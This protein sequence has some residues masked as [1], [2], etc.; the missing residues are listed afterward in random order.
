MSAAEA[1]GAAPP[2]NAATAPECPEKDSWAGSAADPWAGAAQ[3]PQTQ[4]TPQ[5]QQPEQDPWSLD[6]FNKGKGKGSGGPLQCY[7]F[8]GD[9]HPQF[10]CAS[11]KGAGEAGAG[12]VCDNC[13]GTGHQAAACTSKGGGKHTPKGQGKG[14]PTSTAKAQEH[15]AKEARA[16]EKAEVKERSQKLMRPDGFM[17]API[18]VAIGIGLGRCI[19]L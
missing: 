18:L 4:A 2:G 19:P 1:A 9:G 14:Q 15:G 17:L 3:Q 6:A 7:N 8:L 10:L 13:K 12:P 11:D 5:P 16:L